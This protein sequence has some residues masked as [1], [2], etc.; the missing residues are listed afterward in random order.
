[1][2]KLDCGRVQ[3]LLSDH[4]DGT[5]PLAVSAQVQ[6]HLL[7]CDACWIF[8]ESIRKVLHLARD[9]RAFNAPEG[10]SK[11]L[12]SRLE[13]FGAAARPRRSSSTGILGKCRDQ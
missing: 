1:M 8:F 13:R 7:S 6:K 9:P 11:R 12:Y 10:F 3:H 5:L 2:P 4:L